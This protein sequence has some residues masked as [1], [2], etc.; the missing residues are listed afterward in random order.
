MAQFGWVTVK[1]A[2]VYTK[3]AD[4]A[5]LGKAS[6]RLGEE[7]IRTKVSPHLVSGAGS[8]T[9]NFVKSNG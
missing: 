6:S 4:R 8:K 7:Q 5:L 9:K 1:Q 2:E 3:G